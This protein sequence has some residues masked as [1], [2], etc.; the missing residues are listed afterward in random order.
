MTDRFRLRSDA[1]QNLR[2]HPDDGNVVGPDM[3]LDPGTPRIVGSAYTSSSFSALQ[4]TTTTL[5]ALDAGTDQLC[6][7]DP[8]NAGTLTGCKDVAIEVGQDA[9]FDIAAAGA[10]NVGFVATR[11]RLGHGA[12]PVRGCQAPHSSAAMPWGIASIEG[13]VWRRGRGAKPCS[14]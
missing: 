1:G 12:P 8:P 13:G 11:A 3:N 14:C 9:G 6:V 5:Y 4:P 2:L 7:Q 10:R